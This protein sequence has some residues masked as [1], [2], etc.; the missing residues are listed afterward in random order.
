MKPCLYLLTACWALALCLPAQ[1]QSPALPEA[2]KET[3][4]LENFGTFNHFYR[5]EVV[6]A[7][8]EMPIWRDGLQLSSG[9]YRVRDRKNRDMVRYVFVRLTTSHTAETIANYY[10][11]FLGG[12]A[13]RDVDPV[14]GEVMVFSGVPAHCRI[15]TIT[16][17]EG[18]CRVLLE[19]VQHFTIPPREYTAREQQVIRMIDEVTRTYQAAEHVAYAME[20]QVVRASAEAP[21][22]PLRWAVDFRRPHTLAVHVTAQGVS[23][24]DIATRGDRLV[25]TRPEQPEDVREIAGAITAPLV[26]ELQGDLVARLMLG[27]ILIS[28]EIDYLVLL[29]VGD[30]PLHQQVKVVLTFPEESATLHLWID[31]QRNIITQAETV[32]NIDGEETRVTRSYHDTI[33]DAPPAAP[34]QHQSPPSAAV[35]PP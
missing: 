34:L 23:G 1:S 13:R 11:Q 26:P 8:L 10:Q 19:R 5:Q 17:K 25:V 9:V 31:R 29:P 4:Y 2:R 21:A 32:I 14:T 35:T 24:L 20:Q 33:V 3:V 6:P 18:Y 30:A 7:D 15:I 12:S 28:D 27:D 22:P 16:P